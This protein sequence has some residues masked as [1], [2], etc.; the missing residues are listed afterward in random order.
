MTGR[1]T[2]SLKSL[3]KGQA[4]VEIDRQAP[5]PV[6][7]EEVKAHEMIAPK[8]AERWDCSHGAAIRRLRKMRKQGRLGPPVLRRT[9]E[10]RRVLAFPQIG[11]A[12]HTCGD[13]GSKL[14]RVRPGKWQCPACG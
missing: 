13:C 8:K 6:R 10:G 4:L 1:M 7:I 5:V 12:R 3:T 14:D 9:P 2:R 11:R